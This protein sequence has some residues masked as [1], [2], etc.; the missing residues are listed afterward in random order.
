MFARNVSVNLR[1]NTLSEFLKTMESEIVPL[2]RKQK[3]FQDEMTL[4]FPGG[5]EVAA[6]SFWDRKEN[7][8]GYDSS[9]YPKVLKIL[10]RF[11]DRTPHVRTFEVVG[12]TLQK[13][14]GRATSRSSPRREVPVYMLVTVSVSRQ[15]ND[16]IEIRVARPQHDSNSMRDY[17]SEQEAR[18]TLS[19][20]GISEE[21]VSSHLKLLARMG[22]NEQLTFPPM[23]IPRHELLSKGFRL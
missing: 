19:G 23:D 15:D 1:P 22:A 4:S 7:A 5:I 13:H 17:Q 9:G 18:T 8:Q 10:G 12:S 3:G 14:A 16:R 11:L 2:L 20:F 21:T 6:V